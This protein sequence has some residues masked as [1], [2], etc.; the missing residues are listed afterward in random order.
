MNLELLTRPRPVPAARPARSW[1]RLAIGINVAAILI[2]AIALRGWRLGNI[3][4]VN[5]DEAWSGVQAMR[6]ASGQPIAWRT[7]TG[8][9]VNPFYLGPLTALH[10]WLAPTRWCCDCRRW[11]AAWH[12]WR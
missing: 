12:C 8:N 7:P 10:C 11:P 1:A 4:G 6:L 3:P 5:G 2:V 9:P